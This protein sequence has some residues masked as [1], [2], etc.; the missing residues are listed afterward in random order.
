LSFS[1]SDVVEEFR[2]SRKDPS[3][4]PT[5]VADRALTNTRCRGFVGE[6][7]AE[8]LWKRLK[9]LDWQS[10]ICNSNEAKRNHTRPKAEKTLIVSA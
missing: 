8:V 6:Q 4:F 2:A 3:M 10:N 5:G 9:K 7:G 1:D